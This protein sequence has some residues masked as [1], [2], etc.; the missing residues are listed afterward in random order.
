MTRVT[1]E[2]G[3]RV[4]VTFEARYEEE[5]NGGHN[6]THDLSGWD[7]QVPPGSIVEIVKPDADPSPCVHPDC[8]QDAGVHGWCVDHRCGIRFSDTK[9]EG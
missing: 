6:L 3:D 4:R 8:A 1:P 5:W 9:F 2:P 7:I